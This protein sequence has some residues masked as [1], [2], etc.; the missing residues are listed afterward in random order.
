M[1]VFESLAALLAELDVLLAFSDLATSCPTP[2]TRPDI[3]PSV[4][5]WPF[6]FSSCDVHEVRAIIDAFNVLATSGCWR[7]HIGRQ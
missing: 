3:T 7:Y 4:S 1:Q 6:C 5:L 2:Y